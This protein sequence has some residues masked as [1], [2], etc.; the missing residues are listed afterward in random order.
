MLPVT[1]QCPRAGRQ[2]AIGLSRAARSPRSTS[3]KADGPISSAIVMAKSATDGN[4][5]RMGANR[6]RG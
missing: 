2:D 5:T 3:R 4:P 1:F 6:G